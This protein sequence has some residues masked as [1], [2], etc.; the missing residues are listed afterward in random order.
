MSRFT[1]ELRV[2]PRTAWGVAVLAY[3]CLAAVLLWVAFP[4][5]A[6]LSHW[7]TAFQLLFALRIPVCLS[8]YVLLIA[9]INGDARRRCMRYLLCTF[10][11][12][13]IPNIISI[14]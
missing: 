12:L 13:L 2:I 7:P 9:Y 4:N 10:P 14:L 3:A 8:L 6:K 11:S 1:E 5:D